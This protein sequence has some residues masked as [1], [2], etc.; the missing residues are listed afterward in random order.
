M[1]NP[2]KKTIIEKILIFF[3][4]WL[5][6]LAKKSSKAYSKIMSFLYKTPE[7]I[8]SEERSRKIKLAL[9]FQNAGDLVRAKEFIEELTPVDEEVLEL[10]YNLALKHEN[11]KENDKATLIYQYIFKH[12]RHYKDII[13]RMVEIKKKNG[14]SMNSTMAHDASITHALINGGNSEPAQTV[15]TSE[16]LS[17]DPNAPMLGRYRLMKELGKGAMGVVYLGHDPRMN[18][19]VAIKTML[20]KQEFDDDEIEMAKERFFREAESAGK[21]SHPNIV[22]IFDAC[23][24]KDMAYIVMEYMKGKDLSNYMAPT[25]LLPHSIVFNYIADIAEAL[26]YAHASGI[27]HRDI[28]PAN[29]M[30]MQDSRQIKIMDFGIAK[31]ESSRKTKTGMVLGSPSYMSPEQLTGRKLDGRSDLFSLGVT[32][33]QLLTGKLPFQS[34]SMATLLFKIANEKHNSPIKLVPSLH[35]K[36][37]LVFDKILAKDPSQ[38]YQKGVDFAKHLRMLSQHAAQ[39]SK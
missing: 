7:N 10:Y 9:D 37:D 13:N 17:V 2:N 35:P 19:F 38:R 30:I 4:L 16:A 32:L 12:K 33:Y 23:E 5:E 11:I 36:I 18:R 1:S 15:Y 26:D 39:N 6:G 34:D 27:V 14:V 24:E 25:T 20:F 28:K 3:W 29:L 31:I 22:S 21:L 8:V